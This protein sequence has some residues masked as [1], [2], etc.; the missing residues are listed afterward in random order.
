VT[1]LDAALDGRRWQD[2]ARCLPLSEGDRAKLRA[3]ALSALAYA[4][5]FDYPL[6]LDEIVKYQVGTDFS[7]EQVADTLRSPDVA[8]GLHRAGRFVALSGR[9]EVVPLRA[10]RYRESRRIWRRARLYTKWL[11]RLPYV[12]MV[13]VTGAL[14]VDNIGNLPDIDLLIVAEPGRVWLCRRALIALVRVAAL[15]GDELCPNYIISEQNLELDQRDFF[16]AHELA[17]MVPLIGLPVYRKMLVAN[18]WA[19]NY[20]PRG[21]DGA[22]GFVVRRRSRTWQ[23]GP[24]A[25]MRAPGLDKWERWELQRLR[26]KLKPSIGE[27]AEVVCTPEQCKGH[28][29]FH[30]S[31]VMSRFQE[32]LMSVGV[33]DSLPDVLQPDFAGLAAP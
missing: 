30:R 3:S 2:R 4:D 19:R 6:T 10:S 15:F 7:A 24:E 1:L 14:A 29:G 9:E 23:T 16:T 18:S 32:R 27:S 33:A 22:D 13:A 20:L 25:L 28:T 8:A 26:R 21:F 12:R 5:L 11:G 17:Q 31:R